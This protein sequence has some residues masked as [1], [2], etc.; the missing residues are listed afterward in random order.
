M[1]DPDIFLNILLK[2][3]INFFCGVPDSLLKNLLSSLDYNRSIQHIT[4]ANEGLAVSISSGYA[5]ASNKIPVV[6]LQNSGLGNIINPVNSLIH[7]NVYSIPM[8]FIIGWRGQPKFPDEPQHMVQGAQTKSQLKLLDIQIN[9]INPECDINKIIS[10]VVPRVEKGKSQA[11]L[12]TENSFLKKHE[13]S[14]HNHHKTSFTR[15]NSIKLLAQFFTNDIILTTTGKSSR[16]LLKFRLNSNQP[17]RDFLTVGSMGHCSSIALGLSTAKS[18]K[19]KRIVCIDGDGALLMHLG[20]IVSIGNEGPEN[21]VHILI[22]N[23]SHQSVGAQ[24]TPTDKI[25]YAQLFLSVGY[26]KYYKATDQESLL[27]VLKLISL[28]KIQGPIIVEIVVNSE[29]DDP[30]PRPINTPYE[31]KI[32]FQKYIN[33]ND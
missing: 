11:L 22:N 21:F 19:N 2:K 14:N 23:N 6:Y 16:E 1:I 30:L 9:Y 3:G 32:L 27:E 31:N 15:E 24:S 26:L 7:K 29:S 28:D 5:M 17:I 12:V 4:A 18:V 10:I 20:S 33:P 13:L 25:N 8:I